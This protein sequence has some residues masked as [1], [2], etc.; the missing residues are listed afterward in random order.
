M[1][2]T[3]YPCKM[4]GEMDNGTASS[5]TNAVVSMCREL[6]RED[7]ICWA[8]FRKKSSQVQWSTSHK[9]MMHHCVVRP[10]DD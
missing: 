3:Y 2:R 8:C 4:L 9:K 6:W 5:G 7:N 10:G 1:L